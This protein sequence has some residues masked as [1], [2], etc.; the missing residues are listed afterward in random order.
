VDPTIIFVILAGVAV[1]A[2]GFLTLKLGRR[3]AIFLLA[4]G[5]CV[6]VVA[7]ALALLEQARATREAARA[8]TVAA[9]GQAVT[10]AATSITLFLVMV[11]LLMLLLAGGAV[12][13]VLYWRR[14]QRREQLR[15]ALAQA[16]AL[17]LLQGA[18]LPAGHTARPALPQQQAGGNVLVFPG[19]GQQAPPGVTLEDLARAVEAMQ[20]G[21]AD[22]LAGL[23]PPD[24]WEVLG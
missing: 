10:S 12:A 18:R 17:A 8:A 7:V 23:L 2:L 19:G 24:D 3:L 5:G 1:A 20:Q 6:A 9:A 21:R 4:L 11:I 16:Q 13:A 15:D 22:P 14:Y